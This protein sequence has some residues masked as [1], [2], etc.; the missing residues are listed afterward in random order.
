VKEK[1]GEKRKNG[2]INLGLFFCK[3]RFLVLVL[4]FPSFFGFGPSLIYPASSL[5]SSLQPRVQNDSQVKF[6]ERNWTAWTKNKFFCTWRDL[7]ATKK[8]TETK[9]KNSLTYRDKN[10]ILA[11]IVFLFKEI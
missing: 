1:N 11:F 4:Q 5:A 7:F 9:T 3:V 6:F 10:D 2:D 8:D